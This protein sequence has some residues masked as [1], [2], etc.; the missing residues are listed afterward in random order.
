MKAERAKR[1][2]LE[3]QGQYVRHVKVRARGDLDEAG[4]GACPHQASR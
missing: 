4:F 3:G 1:D 2:L